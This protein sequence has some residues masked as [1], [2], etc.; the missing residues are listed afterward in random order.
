RTIG[1]MFW[2]DLSE[3]S[4]TQ[5][6]YSKLYEIRKTIVN[7]H[8]SVEIINSEDTNMF[9]KVNAW[10]DFQVFKQQ[11]NTI[12]EVTEQ[13][14]QQVEDILNL[15]KTH[16]FQ[17]EGYKWAINKKEKLKFLWI[18]YMEK[19]S[20]FYVERGQIHEAIMHNL[21]LRQNLPNNTLVKENL[22]KLYEMIG[23]PGIE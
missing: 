6:L 10:I 19:L 7:Y 14:Y 21:R 23:E 22:N 3:K 20:D 1:N 5:Q 2:S 11:H 15:Y 17:K 16:L 9:V 4:V 12:T 13:N 8:I 18:I